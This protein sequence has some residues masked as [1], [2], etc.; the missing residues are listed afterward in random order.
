MPTA[1]RLHVTLPIL[2][3]TEQLTKQDF[4]D[5]PAGS[6]IETSGDLSVPGLHPVSFQGQQLL[7][8]TRDIAERTEPV[9]EASGE[10]TL[11]SASRIPVYRTDKPV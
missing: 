3:I 8:F 10:S 4:V 6:V 9:T 5:I 2:A 1:V 7:V 11:P